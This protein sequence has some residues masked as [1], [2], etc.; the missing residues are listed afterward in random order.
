MLV[1]LGGE[2]GPFDAVAIYL[3]LLQHD[4]S[5]LSVSMGAQHFNKLFRDALWRAIFCRSLFTKLLTGWMDEWMNEGERRIP[6]DV[7]NKFSG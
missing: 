1:L 3:H 4:C 7:G 2:L 5:V 6:S